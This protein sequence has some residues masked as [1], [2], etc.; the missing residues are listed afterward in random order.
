MQ[1]VAF[2]LGN[3]LIDVDF[4]PFW[5]AA[6]EVGIDRYDIQ[7]VVDFYQNSE[8]CGLVNYSDIFRRE[9]PNLEPH[10]LD[11]IIEGWNGSIH[12]NDQ[13]CNF[14]ECLKH[15]GFKIAYLSNMGPTHKNFLRARESRF[16][17]LADVQHI[18]CEVGVIKPSML[19]FQSF[20]MQHD[21]FAGCMFL[22]DRPE[23]IIAAS[24]CKF[25]SLRFELDS[26][27]DKPPSVLKK[28]L[29]NI[30]DRLLRGC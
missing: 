3:V 23:N 10:N 15:E 28:E 7:D 9:F 30:R 21:D 12:V 29:N 4:E 19:Y 11:L 18:S 6:E 26:F 22:D 1:Y 27:K 8:M 25:D 13:M 14:V 24:K 16:M 2:D 5:I 20:L 17:N